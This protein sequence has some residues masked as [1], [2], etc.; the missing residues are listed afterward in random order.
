MPKHK[1]LKQKKKCTPKKRNYK[2][3]FGKSIKDEESP[4]K[5]NIILQMKI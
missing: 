2:Q 5:K 4:F 1:Q 3:A